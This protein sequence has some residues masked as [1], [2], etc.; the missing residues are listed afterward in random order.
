[1]NETIYKVFKGFPVIGPVVQAAYI[2]AKVKALLQKVEGMQADPRTKDKTGK[3]LDDA[4]ADVANDL[5]EESITPLVTQEGIPSM[6]EKP[7]R[8]K[9]VEQIVEILRKKVIK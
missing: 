8:E 9:A 2:G 5:Y 3:E 1:M 7:I 4:L 6:V